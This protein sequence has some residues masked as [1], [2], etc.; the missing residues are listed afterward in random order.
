V[1]VE[2]ADTGPGIPD[3]LLPRV[4]DRFFRAPGLVVEGTGLGLAICRAIARRHGLSL[5]LRNRASGGLVA[6]VSGS[7]LMSTAAS[8]GS[9]AGGLTSAVPRAL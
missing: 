1:V 3:E 7:A 6:T 2:V 5:T 9:A 8:A 4:F